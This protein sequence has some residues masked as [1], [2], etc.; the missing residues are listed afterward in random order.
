[1]EFWHKPK[2]PSVCSNR[3]ESLALLPYCIF[4][5]KASI[6]M[7]R[8]T[9]ITMVPVWEHPGLLCLCVL[10]CQ[11]LSLLQLQWEPCPCCPTTQGLSH[12]CPA[13]ISS[14]WPFPSLLLFVLRQEFLFTVPSSLCALTHP[15][16]HRPSLS[17]EGVRADEQIEKWGRDVNVWQAQP[18]TSFERFPEPK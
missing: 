7:R 17:S 6:D 16:E 13:E 12:L 14:S 18:W 3:P 9:S 11:F 15:G 8:N 1:M 10:L 4:V 5:R 2:W